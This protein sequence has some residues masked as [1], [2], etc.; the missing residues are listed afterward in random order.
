MRLSL[1]VPLFAVFH[2]VPP[3]LLQDNY[4]DYFPVN[5][6]NK[7]Y[8][9]DSAGEKAELVVR[10]KVNVR[11]VSC[12]LLT[13]RRNGVTEDF[14]CEV[15]P[16]VGLL[17]HKYNLTIHSKERHA[18]YV[19]EYP[20]GIMF[21]PF[22]PD[23]DG[24]WESALES[25]E[26]KFRYV[27]GIKGQGIASFKNEQYQT[28]DIERVVE[29]DGKVISRMS[30]SFMKGVGPRMITLETDE[31]TTTLTL[32]KYDVQKPSISGDKTEVKEEEVVNHLKK[33]LHYS[34]QNKDL[35]LKQVALS[36]ISVDFSG[37]FT[38]L[39]PRAE[40]SSISSEIRSMKEFI[41]K[42]YD[43][44]I[45]QLSGMD[46]IL[47]KYKSDDFKKFCDLLMVKYAPLF[48]QSLY[49]LNRIRKEC[50]LKPVVFSAAASKG[51]MY[52]SYYLD[53][54]G[55]G[56]L[57]TLIDF[58]S[59][60][61]KSRFYSD[62]GHTAAAMSVI[63]AEGLPGSIDGWM[64]TFYHRIPLLNPFTTAIGI[65]LYQET[66]GF[67]RPACLNSRAEV[68]FESGYDVVVY[69]YENQK[70]V[71][72]KF[73][74]LEKPK[75][76]AGVD[77]LTLGYPVTAMFTSGGTLKVTKAQLLTDG[78]GVVPAYAHVPGR[79]TNPERPDR[80]VVC[81]MS[82]EWLKSSAKYKVVIE[83]EIDGDKRTK[84]WS[85]ETK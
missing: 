28:L 34:S 45:K 52:H 44:L 20:F 41:E 47:M 25:K 48:A 80:N 9:K 69:P 67:E 83:Y 65:G 63:A 56:K 19:N 30:I 40:L 5:I 60:D 68:K 26:G 53:S 66:A 51:C 37:S 58:H 8:F 57:Q 46:S 14:Y 21:F 16:T 1:L 42:S 24:E 76:V 22:Y 33:I 72:P 79:P 7:W 54:I 11:K 38:D 49:R 2:F 36:I 81:I 70:G 3:A 71:P 10:S 84:E 43:G 29:R 23:S 73:H 15:I 64:G 55:Y 50:G 82:K 61:K 39:N 6:S 85:F 35:I 31:G 62:E 12:H 18:T 4:S 75:P 77:E 78:G 59:E 13:L 27:I 32:S 17:L 74:G